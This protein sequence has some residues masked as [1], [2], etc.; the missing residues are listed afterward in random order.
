MFS[1]FHY[2]SAI[3]WKAQ[4]VLSF[5]QTRFEIFA[6]E[7]LSRTLHKPMCK[8]LKSLLCRT[9]LLKVALSTFPVQLKSNGRSIQ[10]ER[11]V[12]LN[13]GVYGNL[14]NNK[15]HIINTAYSESTG[16]Q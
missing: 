10:S 9:G 7:A 8:H 3:H 4:G 12:A 5:F 13:R 2:I 14:F 15:E 16:L 11:K 1:T 6:F